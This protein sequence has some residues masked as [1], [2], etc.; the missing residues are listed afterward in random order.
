MRSRNKPAS[1]RISHTKPIEVDS[2]SFRVL[3]NHY[4]KVEFAGKS[5]FTYSKSSL[6][7]A[8]LTALE[9]ARM[10]V[11]IE[12]EDFD[13]Y[14][15]GGGRRLNEGNDLIAAVGCPQTDKSVIQ[16]YRVLAGDLGSRKSK[17]NII[18]G[19]YVSYIVPGFLFRSL[20]TT[21][22]LHDR[23]YAREIVKA[24]VGALC[25]SAM[26]HQTDRVS[27]IGDIHAITEIVYSLDPNTVEQLNGL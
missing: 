15:E 7:N 24:A 12:H 11:M 25:R 9:L 20:F 19:Q 5:I 2:T 4:N 10:L 3:Y 14:L 21:L 1:I 22:R 18:R 13:E 27:L 16:L 23:N 6:Y 8:F 26:K 17:S